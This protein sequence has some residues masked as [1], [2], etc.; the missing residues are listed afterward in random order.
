MNKRLLSHKT[1]ELIRVGVLFWRIGYALKVKW[2]LGL[3]RKS[4]HV[5]A[6]AT[7]RLPDRRRLP[8]TVDAP[9]FNLHI[10]LHLLLPLRP[11]SRVNEQ[12]YALRVELDCKCI[13]VQYILTDKEVSE[14]RIIYAYPVCFQWKEFSDVQVQKWMA[15]SPCRETASG[16]ARKGTQKNTTSAHRAQHTRDIANAYRHTFLKYVTLGYLLGSNRGF[17]SIFLR[18]IVLFKSHSIYM[19]AQLQ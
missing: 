16:S 17:Y 1:I 7:W 18:K 9:A 13:N 10:N 4:A 5:D 11:R 2:L 12:M 6:T 19:A 8:S 3:M 15:C 14:I